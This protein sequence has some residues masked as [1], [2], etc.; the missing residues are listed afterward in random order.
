MSAKGS[1]QKSEE[2]LC[3]SCGSRNSIFERSIEED[4]L[5]YDVGR[6]DLFVQEVHRGVKQGFITLVIQSND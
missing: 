6:I 3:S 4:G 2:Y 5:I 1:C